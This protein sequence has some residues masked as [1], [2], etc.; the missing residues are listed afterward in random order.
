MRSSWCDRSLGCR[1]RDAVVQDGIRHVNVP[2]LDIPE[3][4]I[5]AHLDSSVDHLRAL[6]GDDIGRPGTRVLVHCMQGISRS[7]SI[8]IAYLMTTRNMSFDE[9]HAVAVRA[10][11]IVKPNSGFLAQLRAYGAGK[12]KS[13]SCSD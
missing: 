1:N 9:A 6:L 7:A 2:L 12:A 13:P 4:G 8:V 10:R 5:D 11:P 3:E